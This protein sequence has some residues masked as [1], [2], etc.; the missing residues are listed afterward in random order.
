MEDKCFLYFYF[1]ISNSI[2]KLKKKNHM[3]QTYLQ[4][5]YQ[6]ILQVMNKHDIPSLNHKGRS[7]ISIA[8]LVE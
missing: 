2:R 7:C 6:Q 8:K 1:K 4:L 3:K 5:F